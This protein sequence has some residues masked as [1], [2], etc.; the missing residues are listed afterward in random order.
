[1]LKN[2]FIN[3]QVVEKVALSLEELND[4]VIYVGG[5]VVSLYAT[6]KGAEAAR[7]TKDIDISVQISSYAAME[8]LRER[9]ALKGIYPA[10]GTNVMYRYQLGD[11]LLDFIPYAET[12]LGPTNSWLKPGFDKAFPIQIGITTIRILPVSYFLA[13]KWET[14]KS[15]GGDPRMSHDFEDIIYILDNCL[16]LLEDFQNAEAK[17]QRFLSNMSKE[18]LQHPSQSE[19]IECHMNPFTVSVR[20]EII[21]EKLRAMNQI[22]PSD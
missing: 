3:L 7:P 22:H 8:E 20:K 11:I 4:E 18:I 14:F 1:M 10:Q 13:S 16:E 19:I 17:L 2:Q 21:L 12:P 5:A 6:D 9:L 15:R